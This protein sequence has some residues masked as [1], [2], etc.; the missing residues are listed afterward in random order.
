MKRPKIQQP[1]SL[2]DPLDRVAGVGGKRLEAFAQA[3]FFTILDLLRLAPRRYEDRTRVLMLSALRVD[4]Q[5]QGVFRATL[6]SVTMNHFGA[7]RAVIYAEFAD[8]TGIAR[9]RWFNQPY[10][11]RN[12]VQGK[13]YFLYGSG[14]EL[15]GAPALDNPDIEP[16]DDEADDEEKADSQEASIEPAIKH[17]EWLTPV[18]PSMK[19]LAAARISPRVLRTLIGRILDAVDPALSF[20]SFKNQTSPE[21]PFEKLWRAFVERHRPPS[22]AHAARATETLSFFDQVLFQLGVIKRREHLTGRPDS[23]DEPVFIPQPME[24]GRPLPFPL[25]NDQKLGLSGILEDL[26]RDAPMNRLLQGDVG[27]GKTLVAF[28]SMIRFSEEVQPGSVCA[29]MAPTEPLAR[30]HHATFL[31]FFPELASQAA[32]LTGGTTAADRRKISACLAHSGLRYLFGTHALFQDAVTI[33]GLGFCIIDEQQRF[34]VEHRR[35]LLAKGAN[36][37]IPHLLLISATPIPRSLSL[38]MFGDLDITVIREKPAGR[39]PVETRLHE[40]PEEVLPEIHRTI[41]RGNQI[42]YLCPII[43]TS[44]KKIDWTSLEDAH[45]F[46]KKALPDVRVGILSG[47]RR[48]DEKAAVFDAFAQREIDVLIATTVIEVGIDHPNATL[49]IIENADRFGLSQLHQLRGRVGRGADASTCL[50]ISRVGEASPRLRALAASDD[51]F[52][53]AM[54]DL[55]LRGPGDLVGTRQSGLSHPAFSSIDRPE[56]IE[57]ARRR[58]RE[59]FH[60]PRP[61]IR[62]WFL[63]RMRESFGPEYLTFLD[64]G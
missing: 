60:D 11:G 58:A 49:M 16:A 37:R 47:R 33:P 57:S 51:G 50:L 10:L 44:G 17:C 42:Y 28:L 35:S 48:P 14:F 38:T 26:R 5:A 21:G 52:A 19:P 4:K 59:L 61:G 45:R 30:Q 56:L 13:T 27:S 64:G 24:P 25:T 63:D 7:H 29:M 34:G 12:L 55:R 43:E 3:R 53:I 39:H 6:R 36:G 41:E 32:L 54:E 31:R 62:D 9:A 18:Y 20:P 8:D 23:P 46:L 2:F 15:K 1:L 22:P 40:A